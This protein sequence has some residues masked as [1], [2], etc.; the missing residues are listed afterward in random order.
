M[1]SSHIVGMGM[2]LVS[3]EP[4]R[5]WLEAGDDALQSRFSDAELAYA[6]DKRR[7]DEH[8][9]GR[10]AA[11]SALVK[12]A[13]WDADILETR[14]TEIS[15]IRLPSGQPQFQLG[16]KIA[17]SLRQYLPYKLHLTISH[18]GELAV[19]MV[20]LEHRPFESP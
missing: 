5:A 7:A 18:S 3:L 6:K 11:K 2:E 13:G 12:A 17:E 1:T 8:L 9:A 14:A 16:E 15:I 4:V 19:A 20:V 10:W